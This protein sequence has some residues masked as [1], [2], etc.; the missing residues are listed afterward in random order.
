MFGA[1]GVG[2]LSAFAEVGGY[3]GVPVGDSGASVLPYAVTAYLP[4][5]LT[6]HA[7]V[8]DIRNIYP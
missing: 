6:Q 8:I 3:G 2:G 7:R 4:R 5:V 1:D